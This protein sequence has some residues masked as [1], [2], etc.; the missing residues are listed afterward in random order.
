VLT[1]KPTIADLA[2]TVLNLFGLTMPSYMEGKP[3]PLRGASVQEDKTNGK[4]Q[5]RR[6]PEQEE[7]QSMEQI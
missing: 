6:I 4:S 1:E 5:R 2:P 7:A 3:I